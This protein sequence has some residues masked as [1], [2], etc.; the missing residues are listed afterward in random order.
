MAIYYDTVSQKRY[1]KASLAKAGLST[2]NDNIYEVIDENAS[3]DPLTQIALDSGE[4]EERNGF[5]FVK[6][7]IENRNIDEIKKEM[8]AALAN[9]R[10]EKEIS[11]TETA[12]GTKVLT[13]RESQAS[14]NFIY[15]ALVNNVIVSTQWKSP[16]GWVEVTATEMLSI[17]TA[18]N[19]HISNCFEAEQTV[20]TAIDSATTVNDLRAINLN[21]DFET[22]YSS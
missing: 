7:T 8:K 4:V 16:N 10:Y 19:E 3:Y 12:D 11:G 18:L 20:S 21:A 9:I 6:W 14:T 15:N 5:Y 1:G 17:V 2:N 13:N 22:A